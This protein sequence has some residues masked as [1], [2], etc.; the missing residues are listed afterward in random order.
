MPQV[1]TST[2]TVGFILVVSGTVL[3]IAGTDLV[4]PA[5]PTL[6]SV[7][8]GTPSQAQYVLAAFEAGTGLGLLLFGELGARFHPRWVLA[9]SLAAYGLVSWAGAYAG[10]L[11]SLILL[12]LVQG[13]VGSAPAVLASALLRVL[14]PGHRSMRAI[15]LLGSVESLVPALAPIAGAWLLARFGWRASFVATGVLSLGVA[16]GIA[17]S[18]LPRVAS[19]HNGSYTALLRNPVFLRYALSHALSLGGLLVFV[20]GAP[21]VFTGPLGGHL[22]DFIVLQVVGIAFFIIASNFAGRLSDRFGSEAMI[23]G[24]TILCALGLLAVLIYAVAG[25]ADPAM[26]VPPMI[27]TNLGF[28]LRGPPGFLAA[29]VAAEGDDAR[30]AALT[31]LAILAVASGG[32]VIA[33]PTV[34]TG[35]VGLAAAA[36]AISAAGVAC[37]I[38]L[39]PAGPELRPTA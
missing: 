3:S 31:V 33:A 4:L 18:R 2:A 37:L 25:G 12:R 13:I 24:G 1:P 27:L 7:L 17:M 30:G 5:V 6:P 20:F 15:G 9:A 19:A 14:Y 16:A 22:S 11:E 8:G 29:I 26:L 10:S 23:M 28:G 35:L 21:A 34:A 36:A 39:P 32:T 38:V